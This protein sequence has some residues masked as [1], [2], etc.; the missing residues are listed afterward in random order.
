MERFRSHYWLDTIP[1]GMEVGPANVQPWG[2]GSTD[3]TLR[4]ASDRF[5]L[6]ATV[7]HPKC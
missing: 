7:T 1:F 2:D 3:F 4:L 5:G 6:N